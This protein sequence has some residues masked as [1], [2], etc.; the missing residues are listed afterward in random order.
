M[1][2]HGWIE[3][4]FSSKDR[5]PLI[6]LSFDRAGL[7]CAFDLTMEL[8]LDV[9]NF[10]EMEPL[11]DDFIATLWVSKASIAIPTFEAWVARFCSIL[12]APEESLHSLIETLEHILLYLAMDSLIFFSQR[13]DSRKLIGLHAIGNGH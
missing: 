4:V 1:E 5:I 13:F 3:L 8:D 11:V 7:D 2:S 12:H 6:Y 10:A 9:P